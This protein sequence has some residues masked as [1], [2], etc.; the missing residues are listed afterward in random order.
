MTEADDA[1]RFSGHKTMVDGSHVPLT[2][3]E[4]KALWEA[5]EAA[6]AA[7]AAR[8][9]HTAAALNAIC[10]GKQR[11]REL[12]WR[13]G[14]YCPKDGTDFAAIEFGSTGIFTGH[15][16]G[17]WPYDFAYVEAYGV[18]PHAFMWKAIADLTPEEEDARQRSRASTIAEMDRLGRM[19]QN[20]SALAAH[21]ARAQEDGDEC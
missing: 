7:L 16:P 12:G 5:M 14:S 10:G 13:D 20:V 21:L 11:L 8:L 3:D 2:H 6:R 9:P 4:A 15:F 1:R 19:A 18:H 17:K